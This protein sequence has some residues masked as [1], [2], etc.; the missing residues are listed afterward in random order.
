HPA[1]S[2]AWISTARLSSGVKGVSL[3]NNP[4][5]WSYMSAWSNTYSACVSGSV[6]RRGRPCEARTACCSSLGIVSID[7]PPGTI[8][9]EGLCYGKRRIQSW[10]HLTLTAA[11]PRRARHWSGVLRRALLA[12][13]LERLAPRMQCHGTPPRLYGSVLSHN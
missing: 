2:P 5:S 10:K 7:C 6:S 12:E 4:W 9:T 8:I 1:R 11:A 13:G 3:S